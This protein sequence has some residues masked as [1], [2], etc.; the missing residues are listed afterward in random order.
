MSASRFATLEA[1]IVGVF[2]DPLWRVNVNLPVLHG[3]DLMGT[4]HGRILDLLSTN[5]RLVATSEANTDGTAFVFSLELLRGVVLLCTHR[6]EQM[7]AQP[8][9]VLMIL[10]LEFL[11][12]MATVIVGGRQ[13]PFWWL[14]RTVFHN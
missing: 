9:I 14:A 8:A 11:L 6:A 12:T 7:S 10:A 3:D 4:H 1:V 13:L 2:G 5:Q